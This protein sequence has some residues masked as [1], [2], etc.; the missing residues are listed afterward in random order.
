MSPMSQEEQDQPARNP[1]ADFAH[2]FEEVE[3]VTHFVDTDSPLGQAMKRARESWG[4][5]G[6]PDPDD[7]VF[8]EPT[9]V[10]E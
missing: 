8:P 1:W 2:G 10:D 6:P 7:F 3:Q 9:P 5:A 4:E